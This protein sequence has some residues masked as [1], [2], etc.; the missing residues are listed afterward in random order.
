MDTTD[1]DRGYR[2]Y[3]YDALVGTNLEIRDVAPG[4]FDAIFALR[5]Q[6][7]RTSKI[8]ISLSLLNRGFPESEHNAIVDLLIW[9]GVLGVVDGKNETTFIYEVEYNSHI[10][11]QI[12]GERGRDAE[13]F[14]VN[15]AFWPSL[16]I[17]ESVSA[18]NQ[19]TSL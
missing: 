19:P 6:S 10:I 11:E 2:A 15:K 14:D 4:Y 18:N 17:G 12:R 5:Q 8:D 13:I 3:S 1:F 7:H 9:Y 16:E